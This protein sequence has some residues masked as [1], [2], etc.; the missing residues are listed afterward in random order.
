MRIRALIVDDEVL[1][2][3]R[4]RKL[5]AGEPDLEIM[6]ECSNGVE[7]IACIREQRPDLVFLDVQMPEVSGFDVLRALPEATWPAVI[8]VTAH[9]QHAIAAFEV[10]AVDYLLKPFAQARL[11]AAVQRARQ[12]LQARD[13][14]ALNQQLAAWLKSSTAPQPVYLSRIA[15]KTGKQTLF[16]RVEDIDYIEAA[17]NYAVLQTRGENHILRETLTNLEAKLPPRLFLRISRSIIVNLERIKGI[18]SAPG[19][20]HLL[21]LQDGRQL[22]MTRGARE[23][24]ERLEYARTQTGDA[25]HQ[26]RSAGPAS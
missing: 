3:G 20:E 12:H 5:L 14:A 1:A 16:V 9:D 7:A 8:F 23:V 10:H 17:A 6:G 26:S 22:L 13:L 19:G 21:L 15:V 2:R 4:L 11:L 25:N 24:Q 18:Q